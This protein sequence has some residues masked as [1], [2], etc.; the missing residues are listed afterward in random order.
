MASEGVLKVWPVSVTGDDSKHKWDIVL[1]RK[2][3]GEPY[4]MW[5]KERWA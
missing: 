4:A 1:A 5:E 3:K 2:M